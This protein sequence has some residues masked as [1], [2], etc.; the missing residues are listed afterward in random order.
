MHIHAYTPFGSRLRVHI[1]AY[2][3]FGSC[4]RGCVAAAPA[5]RLPVVGSRGTLAV[6]HAPPRGVFFLIGPDSSRP[7]PFVCPPPPLISPT[8]S[9]F[10]VSA[11]PVSP[12]TAGL[13]APRGDGHDGGAVLPLS[14][15][16]SGG[17][18][19]VGFAARLLPARAW[20]LLHGHA[21]RAW[22]AMLRD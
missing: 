16:W 11:V 9:P 1:H 21:E 19:C 8:L 7:S 22:R 5:G 15:V 14:L 3:P 6:R 18:I 4:L 10:V 2:T 13:C 12:P 17:R 20:L